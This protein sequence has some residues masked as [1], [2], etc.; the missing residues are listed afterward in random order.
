MVNSWRGA[1]LRDKR[2]S[3]GGSETKA[4]LNHNIRGHKRA[5]SARSVPMLNLI[6]DVDGIRIGN[7]HDAALLS[8]V[9]VIL[10]DAPAVASVTVPGGAPGGRDI[11]AL[12]P[13]ATVEQVDAI[14]LSGGSGFGLD[15]ASGAQAW[16]RE[17]GRGL[18][19]G[20]ALVPIVPAAICFDLNNGGNKAWGRYPP[21]RELCHAGCETA[22]GGAFELGTVGGGY[23]TSTVDCKGGLGSASAMTSGGHTVGAIVVVNALGSAVLGA[24]PHFWAAPL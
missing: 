7:M 22:A 19:V 4:Q 13:D 14:V 3:Q 9:T 5:E 12:E 8:G 2:P 15:A 23:G 24:G 16:L 18:P 17:Q 10:F 11:G 21:Y 20:P 6:T 1:G